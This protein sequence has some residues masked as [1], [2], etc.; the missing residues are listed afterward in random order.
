[1]DSPLSLFLT[2][3]PKQWVVVESDRTVILS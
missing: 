2:T 3:C 1:M